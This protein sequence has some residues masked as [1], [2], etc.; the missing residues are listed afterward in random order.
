MTVLATVTAAL[1]AGLLAY[2]VLDLMFSEVRRVRR[3]LDALGSY[4]VDVVTDAQP[5]FAP[6]RERIVGP[7]GTWVARALRAV[8]PQGYLDRLACRLVVSGRSA[9]P[10]VERMLLWKMGGLAAGALIAVLVA[11]VLGARPLQLVRA[12]LVFALLGSYAPD[13]WLRSQAESRQ[14]AIARQLPDMLDMLTISVEAGLGF[15][16]AVMKYVQN[17][18]G[19]LSQEFAV[20]LREVSAGKSRRDALKTLGDRCDVPEVRAFIMAIVQADVFGVSI[21]DVLRVQSREL[22]LKRRQRA[23]ELAQKAPARLVFP[24]VLF[25]MPATL[26]VVIGPAVIRI[27]RVFFGM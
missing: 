17:A 15:D 2:A 13:V 18:R 8:A 26:I 25:I 20:M 9:H 24:L 7:A 4:G 1:A 6:F 19:P 21:S 16:Q 22:R 23:E 27:A 10:G 14:A 5:L 3:R 11:E 12:G